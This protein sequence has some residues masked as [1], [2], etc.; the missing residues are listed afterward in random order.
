MGRRQPPTTSRQ[1]IR[2]PSG[3]PIHC[4]VCGDVPPLREQLRNVSEGG[5]CFVAHIE[6][7]P[8][9]QVRLQIPVFDQQFEAEGVVVWCHRVQAGYEVGVR[10]S[11]ASDRYCVR[12]IEQLCYIE[13]YRREVERD[14]G[15][16]LT[17]EEAA[18]EWIANF[19]AEFP[20]MS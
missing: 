5:V 15:R 6:F 9:Y 14:E 11:Q 20:S 13:E 7:E 16:R 17:S 2:H 4:S 1:F 12:M 3:M 19:A 10:F 18:A 8:G